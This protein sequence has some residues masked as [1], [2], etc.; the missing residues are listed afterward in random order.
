MCSTTANEKD[1]IDFNYVSC[2]YHVLLNVGVSLAVNEL[3]KTRAEILLLG[4]GGGVLTTILHRCFKRVS[5][6]VL[7]LGAS[8]WPVCFTSGSA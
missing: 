4:L 6:G 8:G 2:E 1:E 5:N 7:S 3:K